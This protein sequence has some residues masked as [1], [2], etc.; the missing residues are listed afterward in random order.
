MA[1]VLL[2]C[3]RV[4]DDLSS[5]RYLRIHHLCRE[6]TN[7]HQCFFMDLDGHTDA[8]SVRDALGVVDV[9]G[10]KTVRAGRPSARRHLRISNAHYLRL[11]YPAYFRDTLALVRDRIIQWRI[12]ILLV[13][14]EQMAEMALELATPKIL[15]YADC[16]TLTM[17]RVLANRGKEM[18]LSERARLWLRQVRQGARERALVRGFDVTTT[19]AEPDRQGLLASSGVVA[20]RVVVLPNGVAQEALD[21]GDRPSQPDRSIV[22]WGNLDFPPNWTAVRFFFD[23]VFLPYLADADVKWHIYGRGGGEHLRDVM[24]HPRIQS[25]GFRERLFEEIAGKGVMINPM[26]EGSGLKNKVLEAF[27]CSTLR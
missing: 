2:L 3:D 27:A 1:R 13:L 11:S 17:R 20:E 14:E 19:I 26:V 18:S 16:D 10:A 8:V 12:D 24:E 9:G 7:H 21:A 6:L 4:P 23:S 25:E 22:F 5:G 15:N